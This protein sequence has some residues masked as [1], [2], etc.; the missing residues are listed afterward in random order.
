MNKPTAIESEETTPEQAGIRKTLDFRASWLGRAFG[1]FAGT[2]MGRYYAAF[3][4][5]VL[6]ALVLRLWELGGRTMHYDE[7]IHLYY[8]WRLS[9]FEGFVHSPWMH[10]PFQIEL[11][12][13][14]LRLLGDTD[15]TA[16][17]A[18]VLFGALLV[19]L[20][21]FLR[22]HLGRA[23]ALLTGL[24]L[25]VSPS[26]LYFSRF[27]RN[28]IIMAALAVALFALL[29]HYTQRPRNRYLYLAAALLAVAFASKETAYI[30]TLIFGA[31]AFLLAMPY[32]RIRLP[33]RSRREEVDLPVSESTSAEKVGAQTEGELAAADS[34]R[35]WFTRLKGWLDLSRLNPAAGFLVLLAT[36][37]LPQWSAGVELA[38]DI[39]ASLAGR[40]F[41]REAAAGLEAGFGLTLAGREGI[42][43]GIVGAPLWDAPFVRLPLDNFPLWLPG[44]FVFLIIALCIFAGWK[45]SQTW[46][47]SAA[48]VCLPVVIAYAAA[49][50][51]LSPIGAGVDIILG[52]LLA[53][54]CVVAFPYL[55]LPWRH[56][57]FLLFLPALATMAYCLLFLPVLQ[58]DALLVNI[59]PEGIQVA[60]DGNAVPLNFLVAGGILLTTGTVSLALGLWWRGGTWLICAAIFYGVWIALFTTFF[61][62]PAG[63][64]SG[65][66]QGMGYWIAQQDVARGN[67]PWYYYLV[68]LSVYEFLPVIFGAHRR[69]RVRPAARPVRHGPGFLGR[70][71]FPGLHHCQREDALAAG[72]HYPALH[73]P[74]REVVGRAD[75][76]DRLANDIQPGEPPFADYPAGN[77]GDSPDR[78]GLRRYQGDQRQPRVAVS[79]HRRPARVGGAGPGRRLAGAASWP[80]KGPGRG[81]AGYRRRPFRVHRLDGPSSRL[82]LRRFPAGDSGVRP[83]RR[84]LEGHLPGTG[85]GRV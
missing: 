69:Y 40:L 44:I 33:F 60:S 22:E 25:A 37:T 78:L 52:V 21:Y 8:S 9:N 20:P 39:A 13:L 16:R 1:Y 53:G 23:G 12:A 80:A 73:F 41:G 45:L 18:Y 49:L 83:G 32:S 46:R 48:A 7:A 2:E 64:F 3:A 72:Q 50:A 79:G 31:L 29:W 68:G 82:H 34:G 74:G 35:G 70:G 67:Q 4:A 15:F 6:V 59:L 38:R 30:I 17:L 11:V 84:R 65:V 54:L 56:S 61:T 58:V 28:D 42:G 66:W 24:L 62:N 63:L 77:A 75:R 85:A 36:L 5:L 43:Q 71:K 27:G 55:Q 10:G 47:Q 51:L 81:R 19:F 14:F 76:A 57:L 26:L